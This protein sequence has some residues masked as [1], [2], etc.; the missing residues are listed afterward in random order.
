M[1]VSRRTFMF[2]GLALAGT[3]ALAACSSSGSAVHPVAQTG[4]A[5]LSPSGP[6][7]LAAEQAR[8]GGAVRSVTLA[9]VETAADLGAGTVVSTW[10]YG[11]ALPGRP[12]RV[13]AG[14]VLEATVVNQLPQSTTIHWHGL[15][16]R[17]DMDGVPGVTQDPIAPGGRFRYRFTV[18]DPG[19]YWI[20][21]H[22]GV[23]Q[24]RGL[25][26]PLIVDDP[27]EPLSY[28][29]EWTVV[30]DDWLDGTG[31]TPDDVLARLSGGMG[32]MDHGSTGAMPGGGSGHG[33]GAESRMLR[34]A[35]S[36]ALGGDPGDVAYTHYL[37]N[38]RVPA[39][40]DVFHGKPGQRV[41][42]RIL[43]AGGDTAFRVALGGHTMTVTHADGLPVR[44]AD[45]KSLLLGMGERYDVLV[46]LG[47]G[48]F[49]FTASAEGK[50]ALARALVR[51]APGTAPDPDVRPAELDGQPLVA[52][53]LAPAEHVALPAKEIDRTVRLELTGGMAKYDWGINGRRYDPAYRD[54]VRAGERVRLEFV[55]KTAMWHPMH[56]HGHSFAMA[57]PGMGGARKDTAAILP[58]QTLF[59][60]FDADNPG[61]WMIH[62]HNV[63]HAETG[64]MSLLGYEV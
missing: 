17:N 41:R 39:D 2:S 22:T 10:T 36:K 34:G 31:T 51:T 19:T 40:P 47:S 35:T 26:A 24:D 13:T 33:N 53:R 20:H 58:G 38:G 18:P 32:G 37:V 9:A 15:R 23:Q 29:A 46:T 62:C 64:M 52:A 1:S 16:L 44:Q 8:G 4:A 14:E 12:I 60:D 45:A 3:G 48:V 54:L 6:E 11:G 5:Y 28:D 27:R 50:N 42:I 7:V 57:N 43:N 21:P 59:A 30:L 56:L 25:Y 61:L 55:N 49:P 63:Y